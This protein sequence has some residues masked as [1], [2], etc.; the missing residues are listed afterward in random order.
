[1]CSNRTNSL[2]RYFVV[3]KRTVFVFVCIT[4][5]DAMMMTWRSCCCCCYCL[6]TFSAN[7]SRQLN[8]LGHDGDAFGVNSAQVSIFEETY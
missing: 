5:L 6:G 7:A 3:L 2:A 8:I 1:M 4:I